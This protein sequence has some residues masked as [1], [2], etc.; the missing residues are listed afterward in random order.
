MS[1]EV[2]QKRK[3]IWQAPPSS[4][5]ETYYE[6]KERINEEVGQNQVKLELIPSE[7]LIKS[8]ADYVKIKFQTGETTTDARLEINNKKA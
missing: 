2:N 1:V 3:N 6:K 7:S 8:K 5:M 4:H